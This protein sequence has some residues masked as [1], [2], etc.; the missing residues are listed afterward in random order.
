MAGLAGH[1]GLS[2]SLNEL[3]EKGKKGATKTSFDYSTAPLKPKEGLNGP[4][5]RS[6]AAK[7]R[8]P[9]CGIAW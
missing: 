3:P 5:V 7:K 1:Y 8:S 9:G 6:E 2:F 4:F